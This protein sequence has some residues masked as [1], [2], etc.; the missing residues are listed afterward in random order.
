MRTGCWEVRDAWI[1]DSGYPAGEV[2]LK[3]R[4]GR[5]IFR[6]GVVTCI[7]GVVSANTRRRREFCVSTAY[8]ALYAVERFQRVFSQSE[9]RSN[10]LGLT[11]GTAM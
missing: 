11:T 2:L 8:V 1:H 9:D 6:W 10:T 4:G 5:S 7:V 3:R